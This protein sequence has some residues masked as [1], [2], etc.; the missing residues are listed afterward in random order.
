M[1]EG[2]GEH[3]EIDTYNNSSTIIDVVKKVCKITKPNSEMTDEEVGGIMR[4]IGVGA[5]DTMWIDESPTLGR[6]GIGIMLSLT[7]YSFPDFYM[8]YELWQRN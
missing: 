7:L 6:I 8:R 3:G 2:Y 1:V 4:F 5:P